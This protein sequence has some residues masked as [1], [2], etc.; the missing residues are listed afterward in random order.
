MPDPVFHFERAEAERR[1]RGP[2]GVQLLRALELA[3]DAVI[4]ATVAVLYVLMG[5]QVLA[6]WSHVRLGLELR[7]I[8]TDM[9]FLL[10]LVEVF[11]LLMHYLIERRVAVGTMVE[12]GIISVLREVILI[13]PLEIPWTQL[14]AISV[15]LVTLGVL[16]RFGWLGRGAAWWWRRGRADLA[17]AAR[18]EGPARA[19]RQVRGAARTDLS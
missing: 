12:I 6:M 17:A 15:L 14:L 5:R 9:L 16:L 11:R 1:I 8:L 18:E 4:V 13:G 2:R 19:R 7:A 3:Q 10:I